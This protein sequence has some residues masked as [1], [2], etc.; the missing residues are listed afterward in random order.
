MVWPITTIWLGYI[1]KGEVRALLG[2]ITQFKYKDVEANFDKQLVQAELEATKLKSSLPKEW[3]QA[4][5]R[6]VL[7]QYEQLKRIAQA[8]PRAAIIEAWLDVEVA[9]CAAAKK[10]GLEVKFNFNTY[11]LANK[12][13]SLDVI[14]KETLSVFNSLRKLRNQTT[15]LPDFTLSQE[16]ADRYLDLALKVANTFRHYALDMPHNLSMRNDEIDAPP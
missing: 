7:T 4:T 8:S 13:A 15:H 3:E 10:A 6:G 11:E 1:F 2:R 12:L 14:P 16:E 9:V 5:L